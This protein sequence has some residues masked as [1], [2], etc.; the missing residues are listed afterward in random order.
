MEMHEKS[1]STNKRRRQRTARRWKNSPGAGHPA[2][3]PDIRRLEPAAAAMEQSKHLQGPDIWPRARTSGAWAQ[4]PLVR[5][6]RISGRRPRHPAP[7]YPESIK[8]GP[9]HA[10]HPAQSPDIRPPLHTPDIRPA[11][12]DIRPRAYREPPRQPRRARHPALRPDIRPDP[13]LPDIRPARPDVRPLLRETASHV[14]CIPP[15]LS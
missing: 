12:P 7:P 4:N 8:T 10:R 1:E 15:P 6:G 5:R 11:R 3:G 2:K 13:D 14:P 9:R